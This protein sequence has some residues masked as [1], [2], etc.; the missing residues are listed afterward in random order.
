MLTKDQRREA[1]QNRYVAMSHPVRGE[2][3]RI[4]IEE[5]RPMSPVQIARLLHEK[6]E[7]V[8]HH[9]KRLVK[10]DCAELVEERSVRGA[11][12]HFYRATERS[13]VSTEEWHD[14]HPVESHRMKAEVVQLVLDD[15]VASE[16]AQIAAVDDLFQMTRTPVMLDDE[17]LGES[18][19]IMERA[20]LEVAEAETRSAERA[21]AGGQPPAPASSSYLLFRVPRADR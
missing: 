2:A 10:L 17:G 13:L 5:R 19:E 8:S 12:E 21:A 20:R 1:I 4:L 9:I 15:F 6:T 18:Q 11:V 3:L 14:V 16:K 7:N